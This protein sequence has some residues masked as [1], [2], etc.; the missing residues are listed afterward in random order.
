MPFSFSRASQ[1]TRTH[2]R[3]PHT[4]QS[5]ALHAC[6]TPRECACICVCVYSLP[7]PPPPP[8]APLR[9]G[10]SDPPLCPPPTT[11][12]PPAC[13]QVGPSHNRKDDRAHAGPLPPVGDARRH[14]PLGRH[15]RGALVRTL[16]LGSIS[17]LPRPSLGC[18]GGLL[19]LPQR[20]QQ[21]RAQGHALARTLSSGPATTVSSHLRLR[22]GA[23]ALTFSYSRA[24]QSSCI[25]IWGGK[26]ENY[27]KAQDQ[28]LARAQANAEASAGKYV[29]GSQ[30]SIEESLFVKNYVY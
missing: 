11:S 17:A 23:F 25:K 5:A 29:P 8:E 15:L 21:A 16:H 30:P 27:Q 7:P 13:R 2:T 3:A 19:H 1:L 18:V 6:A 24:L 20:D 26:E 4:R 9:E 12:S 14:L 28:L 10:V 22:A